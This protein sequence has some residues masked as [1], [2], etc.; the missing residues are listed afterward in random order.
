MQTYKQT[1]VQTDRR[2]DRWTHRQTDRGQTDR[3]TDRQELST[4][5]C[6]YKDIDKGWVGHRQHD[7]ERVDILQ[8]LVPAIGTQVMQH[9]IHVD[10]FS[11]HGD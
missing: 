5:R 11:P 2:V 1:D 3:R 7:Q 6:T 4:V 9:N 10:W 8:H